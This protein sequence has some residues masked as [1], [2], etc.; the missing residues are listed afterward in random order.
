MRSVFALVFAL[1]CGPLF[2]AGP[3]CKC[4]PTCPCATATP[5]VAP[6]GVATGHALLE[7]KG[8]PGAWQFTGVKIDGKYVDRIGSCGIARQVYLNGKPATDNELAAWSDAVVDAQVYVSEGNLYFFG[9]TKF[10]RTAPAQAPP[11]QQQQWYYPSWSY[12]S[13]PSCPNGRCPNPQR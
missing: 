1:L 4:H 7:W 8:S 12:P 2:A 3:T 5:T 6:R 11:T 9:G 13:Y 10:T